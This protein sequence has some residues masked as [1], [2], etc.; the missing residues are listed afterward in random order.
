MA[1]T[2]T[3]S[4]HELCDLVDDILPS[5][6]GTTILK[7]KRQKNQVLKSRTQLESIGESM[8]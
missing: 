5:A 4:S 2:D 1:N 3:L 6:F 8:S 7:Q